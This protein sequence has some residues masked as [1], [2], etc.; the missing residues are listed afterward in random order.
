MSKK[1]LTNRDKRYLKEYCDILNSIDEINENRID[2]LKKYFPEIIKLVP[3]E[4][5]INMRIEK[6]LTNRLNFPEIF[7]PKS[8]IMKNKEIEKILTR[9][10]I[11]NKL[12]FNTFKNYQL[13]ETLKLL[14]CK[15]MDIKRK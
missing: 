1:K 10:K 11:E 6:I 8:I 12:K 3:N 13:L 4:Q 5:T 7:L 15:Y 9:F 2:I 14:I